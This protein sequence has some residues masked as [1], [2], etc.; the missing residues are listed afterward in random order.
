MQK[1]KGMQKWLKDFAEESCLASC[2]YYMTGGRD[3]T[4][5]LEFLDCG[6][7]N[8]D[9]TEEDCYVRNPNNLTKRLV[10]SSITNTTNEPQI[11]RFYNP[12][13]GF[14]HFVVAEVKDNKVIVIYDPLEDSVTVKEG[15]VK[16]WR[17]VN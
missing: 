2:Y 12:R 17:I 4:G 5:F 7:R 15:F 6:I 8:G 13:T 9:I 3:F 11:A 10:Y 14:S 16:D 1:D